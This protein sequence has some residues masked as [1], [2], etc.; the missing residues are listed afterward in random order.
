MATLTLEQRREV[1]RLKYEA[2]RTAHYGGHNH[3]RGAIDLIAAQR[4]Q[5]LYDFGCGSNSF[6]QELR[7]KGCDGV[8]IDFANPNADIIAPIHDVPVADGVA[9]YITS[10]DVMEHVLLEDVPLVFA[11]MRRI[12]APGAPFVFSISYRASRAKGVNGEELHVTIRPR[13]WWIDEIE[14]FGTT[15]LYGKY[16]TGRFR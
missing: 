8:G 3:G 9:D 6:L 2:L 14:E 7:T 4:P 13:D 1:E 11:E 12:A 16:I 15:E 10:F 5:R